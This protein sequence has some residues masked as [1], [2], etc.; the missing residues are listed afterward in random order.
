M[1]ETQETSIKY[2][3]GRSWDPRDILG[4]M[5][6]EPAGLSKNITKEQRGQKKE[7]KYV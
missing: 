7:H 6:A 2:I 5:P 4:P 3:Q 1:R